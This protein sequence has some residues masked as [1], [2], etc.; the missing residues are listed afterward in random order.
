MKIMFFTCDWFSLDR[1][2]RFPYIKQ[3]LNSISKINATEKILYF[4]CNEISSELIQSFFD[5]MNPINIKLKLIIEKNLPNGGGSLN[6]KHKKFLKHFIESDFDYFIYSENDLEFRQDNLN[7][8]IEN[9]RILKNHGTNF[10]PSFLRYEIN[11]QNKCVSLDCTY[12]INC[13]DRPLIKVEDHQFISHPQ[14]YQSMFI[15]DKEDAREHLSSKYLSCDDYINNQ[16]HPMGWGIF[17]SANA[18]LLIENIPRNFEH[19]GVISLTDI[20]RCFIHHLPN[21]Y[22]NDPLKFSTIP[23]DNLLIK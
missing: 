7:Y 2:F 13:K 3:F 6:W 19:R 20:N 15:L 9:R 8:W 18:A 12:Q 21:K 14:P 10:I 5:Y 16:P 11:E 17:E 1:T 22:I 23:I 4:H